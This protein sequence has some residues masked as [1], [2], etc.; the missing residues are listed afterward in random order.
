M[1]EGTFGGG[2][3]HTRQLRCHPLPEERASRA[4]KSSPWGEGG[5]KAGCGVSAFIPPGDSLPRKTAEHP[6]DGTGEPL[7]SS[8]VI[9]SEGA[10][11]KVEERV[12]NTSDSACGLAQDD[13][14]FSLERGGAK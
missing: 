5:R 13:K 4:Q 2:H 11:R 1:P 10:Y 3:P 8:V 7:P 14:L 12:R 9:L 6:Y